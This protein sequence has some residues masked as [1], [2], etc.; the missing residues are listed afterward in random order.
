MGIFRY[1]F[2][3]KNSRLKVCYYNKLLNTKKV[4]DTIE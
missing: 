1:I 4:V 3:E 2:R